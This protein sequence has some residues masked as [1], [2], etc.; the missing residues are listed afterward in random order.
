MSNSFTGYHGGDS[1][2][3]GQKMPES[4]I[5]AILRAE[6]IKQIRAVSNA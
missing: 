3:N 2:Y 4:Q 5:W 6:K 1:Y